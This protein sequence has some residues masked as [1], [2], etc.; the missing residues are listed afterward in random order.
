MARDP[1][2]EAHNEALRQQRLQQQREDAERHA[3]KGRE[4]S[5]KQI[6]HDRRQR[7]NATSKGGGSCALIFLAVSV[8]APS[9]IAA[10]QW[11]A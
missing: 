7:E 8:G 5:Q 3:R 11:L 9:A 10:L 2:T 1:K 6:D 4:Q